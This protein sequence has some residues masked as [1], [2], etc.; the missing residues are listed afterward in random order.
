MD[1]CLVATCPWNDYILHGYARTCSV[2]ILPVVTSSRLTMNPLPLFHVVSLLQGSTPI[3]V[4]V[5]TI[6][7]YRIRRL[8]S[9]Q[10]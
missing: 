2:L 5:G 1:C 10:Q 8:T 9:L 6:P 3:L 7:L 4:T